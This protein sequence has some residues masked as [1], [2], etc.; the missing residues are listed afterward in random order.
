MPASTGAIGKQEETESGN[1][2][3]PA[4]VDQQ[5]ES[6]LQNLLGSSSLPKLP[7]PSVR[8]AMAAALSD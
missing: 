3:S 6:G 4:G 2:I 7:T 5:G 8:C 1:L